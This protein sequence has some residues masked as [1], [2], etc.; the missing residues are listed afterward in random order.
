MKQ[1]LSG[2]VP[3]GYKCDVRSLG[4]LANVP[5]ATLYRTYPHLKAQFDQQLGRLREAGTEP[6]PR[7]AQVERLKG[8]VAALRDRLSRANAAT[9]DLE[10]FRKMA[11]SRLAAQ[12]EEIT[13]LRR[14]LEAVRASPLRLAV[15]Q[16][17]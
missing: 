8:E 2:D 5:R 3:D 6:D 4:A 14:D 10:T 15:R 1:L 17:E 12:Q 9:A 16:A 7:V 11:L 13:A